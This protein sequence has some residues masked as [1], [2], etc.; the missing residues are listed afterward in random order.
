MISRLAAALLLTGL[1]AACATAP[2][3][4]PIPRDIQIPPY[5]KRP[6]EPFSRAAA[7]QIALR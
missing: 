4:P 2:S 3:A 7:V 5:A 1:L 6:Y